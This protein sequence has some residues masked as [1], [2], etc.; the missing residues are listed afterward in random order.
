MTS[1]EGHLARLEYAREE[2]AKRWL[3]R[4]IEHSS[5]DEI[6]GLPTERIARELPELILDVVRSAADGESDP[7]AASPDR[8]AEARRFSELAGEG[9][10]SPARIARDAAALQAL[11][12]RELCEVGE[13]GREADGFADAAERLALAVGSIQTA[14]VEELISRRSRELECEASTD[15]LTGLY[16]LRYLQRV[17]TQLVGYHQ[18]YDHPFAM[19]LLD[20]DGLKR[21]NDAHGQAA[22]DRV[23]VQVAM[24]VRRSVRTVDT[25]ARLG[26]DEFIVLAPHQSAEHASVLARRLATAV[27]HEAALPD[28]PT[29]GVSIGVVACP[30][31]AKEPEPLLELAD[32]AMYRAKASGTRVAVGEVTADNG[33]P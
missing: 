26:G 5:L 31:H 19:L 29:V 2:I 1:P 14:A 4:L 3:V 10:R 17:M 13:G 20:V 15:T 8:V 30:E 28:G 21:I 25:P 23:L 18:R 24:A 6:K 33:R 32:Q 11:M 7:L 16:N 27:E 22:G 9:D 12:L